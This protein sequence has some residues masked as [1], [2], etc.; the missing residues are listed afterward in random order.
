MAADQRREPGGLHVA[1]ALFLSAVPNGRRI[2]WPVQ[3]HAKN[4][5]KYPGL[6]LQ[7]W[8]AAR[9]IIEWDDLGKSIFD[10]AAGA[11]AVKSLLRMASG[12][13]NQPAVLAAG[14]DAAI[15]RFI[16]ISDAFHAT[17]APKFE[18]TRE[19]FKANPALNAYGKPPAKG[20]KSGKLLARSE[21][22]FIS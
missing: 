12:F 2:I 1:R 10:R 22:V 16:P 21:R 4:P 5:A 20:K 15:K 18:F 11:H 13:A 14:Y 17:R 8:R 9:D 3:T 7:P 6:D 19:D